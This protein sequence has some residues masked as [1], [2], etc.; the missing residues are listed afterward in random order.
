MSLLDILQS[1]LA[2]APTEHLGRQMGMD[3]AGAQKAIGAALPALMAALA[4][5]SRKSAGASS[6]AAALDKDH[7]GGILDDLEGSAGHLNPN[8]ILIF[9]FFW[10]S[11]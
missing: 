3:Q 9:E 5:N 6:L 4:G 8:D 1:Q 2:G 7:D 10:Y 11:P